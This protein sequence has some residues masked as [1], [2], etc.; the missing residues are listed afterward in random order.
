MKT[1][2]ILW[3]IWRAARRSWCRFI[4]DAR[5]TVIDNYNKN[6]GQQINLQPNGE[7]SLRTFSKPLLPE[8]TM[9]LSIRLAH[10]WR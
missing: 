3:A 8:S 2:F 1:I 6:T 7:Q 5:Y 9:R 10:Y 4:P